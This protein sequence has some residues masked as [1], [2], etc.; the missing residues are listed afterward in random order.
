MSQIAFI[1]SGSCSF[2]QFLVQDILSFES[3]QDSRFTFM[4][5][6]KKKLDETRILVT[7]FLKSKGLDQRPLYTTNLK[8]ALEGSDFVINLVK[9]GFSEGAIAD[10]EIPK[11]YGILQTIGDT[12]GV[13]G[14][15]RGLRTIPFCIQL[16]KE[17]EAWSNPNAVILNYT[18]PQSMLVMAVAATS[19]VPFI[20]LCHSVRNTTQAIANYLGIPYDQL[21]FEAAGVN[22]LNWITKLHYKDRDIYPRLR[23][24]AKKR[25]IDFD[26]KSHAAEKFVEPALGPVRIDLFNRMGY[27]MTESSWHNAE[28]VPY[29]LR[30]RGLIKKYRLPIDRYYDNIVRKAKET[31]KLISQAKKGK[32]PPYQRSVEYGSRIIHAMVTNEPCRIYANVP[33]RG[34]ISNL[35]EFSAVEVA[36]LVD[37]NGV[38]PCHYGALPT[39]L[40]ALCQMNISVYQ[41]AVEAILQKN[42]QRVYQAL[43]MDPVTHSMLTLDQMESLADEL[44]AK[45]K[46]YLN[47]YL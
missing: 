24:L 14:I 31:K 17:V 11:K 47:R 25:G 36:A 32:L 8:R 45:H 15:F 29:Y 44:I 5:V 13:G 35:P 41:M 26:E 4:D 3:L 40:A 21:L 18:N 27:I 19:K 2:T 20:G 1:G 10:M 34:L 6:D 7:A 39:H 46:K 37:R 22:H 43:M 42:R 16:C 30:T 28:Y 9:I 12:C 33:N 38:Q 23:R